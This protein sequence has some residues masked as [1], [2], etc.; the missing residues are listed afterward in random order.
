MNTSAPLYFSP[1][2]FCSLQ[3][4][5]AYLSID[6]YHASSSLIFPPLS[7]QGTAE[8]RVGLAISGILP[9]AAEFGGVGVQVDWSLVQTCQI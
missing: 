7:P 3:T 4:F 8:A 9:R 5:K 2:L 6:V 1:F